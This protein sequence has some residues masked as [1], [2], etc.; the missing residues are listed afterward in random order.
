[1]LMIMVV[2]FTMVME[3]SLPLIVLSLEI[4]LTVVEQLLV[5]MYLTVFSPTIHQLMTVVQYIM[6]MLKTVLS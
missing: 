6:V 2:Q 3:N 4:L 1:M 5:S